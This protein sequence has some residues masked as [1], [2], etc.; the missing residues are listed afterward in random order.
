MGLGMIRDCIIF[1]NEL[2]FSHDKKDKRHFN[3]RYWIIGTFVFP[4]ILFHWYKWLDARYVGL[5]AQT[6]IKKMLLDQFVIS[7]PILAIFYVLMSVMERKDDI[8]SEL[9]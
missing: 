5:A 8:F 1:K 6:I 7:P 4:V 3:L 2:S 9:R